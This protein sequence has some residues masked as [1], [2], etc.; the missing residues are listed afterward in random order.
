MRRLPTALLASVAVLTGVTSESSASTIP[1]PSST[2]PVISSISPKSGPATGGTLVTLH[3][4]HFAVVAGKTKVHFGSKTINAICVS[5]SICV[6]R[7]PKGTG[8]VNVRV[9]TSGGT[10][11]TT[12]ASRFV[13]VAPKSSGSGGAPAKQTTTTMLTTGPAGLQGISDRGSVEWVAAQWV[14]DYYS[15]FYKWPNILYGENVLSAKFETAA[16]A[17]YNLKNNLAT[18]VGVQNEW[19]LVKTEKSGI[20]PDITSA[21]VPVGAGTCVLHCVVVVQ[22]TYGSLNS[23]G[24]QLPAAANAAT[25]GVSVL[26]TK[27]GT[28]WL[29]SAPATDVAN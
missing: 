21:D 4:S 3:G 20:Y 9:S 28:K 15:I 1:V 18:N 6:A 23:S 17:S 16:F 27:V 25:A 10:S 7:S 22:W 5:D 8:E 26:L 2:R 29:V 12:A 24:A 19:T 11:A 13:F 14:N